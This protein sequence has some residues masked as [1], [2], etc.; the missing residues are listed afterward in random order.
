MP[1]L[2]QRDQAYAYNGHTTKPVTANLG[3]AES[4]L[5]SPKVYLSARLSPRV[6]DVH[7]TTYRVVLGQI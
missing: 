1:V 2:V 3:Y 7:G 4:W 6:E 5:G